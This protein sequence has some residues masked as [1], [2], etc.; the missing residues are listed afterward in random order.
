MKSGSHIKKKYKTRVRKYDWVIVNIDITSRPAYLEFEIVIATSF[1]C[2]SK[3]FYLSTGN[4]STFIQP[5]YVELRK[6]MQIILCK[7]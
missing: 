5:F 1:P 3:I 4:A 6:V 7:K 2:R